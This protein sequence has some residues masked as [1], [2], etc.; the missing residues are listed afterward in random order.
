MRFLLFI[1]LI[2]SLSSSCKLVPAEHQT[3]SH[4]TSPS[5][6]D[7]Y[8]QNSFDAEYGKLY[9]I[10]GNVVAKY[11]DFDITLHRKETEKTPLTYM[12]MNQLGAHLYITAPTDGERNHFY[13]KGKHFY[14]QTDEHDRLTIYVPSI[15]TASL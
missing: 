3:A 2:P 5:I 7:V 8:H 1:I 4:T 12:V 10:R 14:Y 11:P 15:L 6:P 9:E 13:F